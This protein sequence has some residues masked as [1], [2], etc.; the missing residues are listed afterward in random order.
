M[1]KNRSWMLAAGALAFAF[2]PMAHAAFVSGSFS[3]GNTSVEVTANE[4]YFYNLGVPPFVTPTGEFSILAPATGSFAAFNVA[5]NVDTIT[6]LTQLASDPACVGCISAPT[7]TTLTGTTPFMA[8]P[9]TG[10][11]IDIVLTGLAAGIDTPGTPVCGT[12]TGAQLTAAGTSCTPTSTSPFILSNVLDTTSGAIDTFVTITGSGQSYFVVSPTQRSAT[13]IDLS[14]SFASE[15][16]AGVLNTLTTTGF[17]V[18]SLQGSVT[19]TAPST[20]P[21]PVGYSVVGAGLLAFGLLR[22]KRRHIA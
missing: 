13:V 21:E 9:S 16:I 17:I 5:G 20:V 7:D 11:Q 19:A 10:T 6:D 4:M 1:I 2:A 22:R 18:G 3:P 15:T 12:L 14:T 8:I